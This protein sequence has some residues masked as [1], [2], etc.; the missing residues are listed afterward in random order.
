MAAAQLE[1]AKNRSLPVDETVNSPDALE[2]GI[3][4]LLDDIATE[5]QQEEINEINEIA[6]SEVSDNDDQLSGNQKGEKR[7]LESDE[8]SLKGSKKVC[9]NDSDSSNQGELTVNLEGIEESDKNEES[10]S[11]S[12]ISTTSIKASNGSSTSTKPLIN[13]TDIQNTVPD[14]VPNNENQSESNDNTDEE[15]ANNA[16]DTKDNSSEKEEDDDDEIDETTSKLL[17]SGISISLIK[18]KKQS[19]EETPK[20]NSSLKISSST[21][22]E[23]VKKTNPLEVGPHISVTMVNKA[24]EQKEESGKFSISLKKPSELMDPSK[25][26]TKSPSNIL[27]LEEMKDTISVS[28]INKSSTATSVPSSSPMSVASKVP[29]LPAPPQGGMMMNHRMG[30][31]PMGP[32]GM[33][34]GMGPGQGP[35]MGMPGLQPRPTGPMIRPN[36]PLSG[37]SISDQLNR[38]SSN[39]ADYMRLGLEEML[40]E[41]SAHGSPEATI[42]GLQLEIEKMQWRHTQEITEMKQSVDMMVKDMKANLEKET[43]RTIDAMKKQAEMEKQKAI[44]ETKKKQW[45]ANCSK[46]AIFYCCWNTSYCD[47]PCQQAHWPSHMS[48][49]SQVG[50]E[51]E[52]GGETNN[53]PD[54]SKIVSSHSNHVTS[55]DHMATSGINNMANSINMNSMGFSMPGMMGGMRPNMNN[56]RHNPLGVSIRPG[57]PGQLT[58]S[59]P[60]F[61]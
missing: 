39:L 50:N 17:A 7:Q 1:S 38:I 29:I 51:D 25:G 5:E 48:T 42:K 55:S 54:N 35:G 56:M 27:N 22:S 44:T 24:S 46:E 47:Y 6:A 11:P 37:G 20:V 58:I 16:S 60:Y 23:P 30:Y 41:L 53:V 19:K 12:E 45:C 32:R 15:K 3:T 49:C 8:D 14:I 43:Q 31:P 9:T 26:G 33:Y 2:E 10:A 18:K 36:I 28:R 4:Q 34:Q 57:M 52:N 59:R 13:S 40:K 21:S 61:M